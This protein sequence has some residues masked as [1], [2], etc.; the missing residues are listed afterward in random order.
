MTTGTTRGDPGADANA[1]VRT[2]GATAGGAPSSAPDAAL[3]R[4][5]LGLHGPILVLGAS[6]FV[7]A[8]LLRMLLAVRR[9]AYGTALRFPAWRLEGLPEENVVATDLLVPSNLRALLDRV[10]PLTVFDC[11]AYGAYSYERD[12]HL[13]HRTNAVFTV[14]LAEELAA[15]GIRALVHAGSS[16]EYGG[17][18]AAP[19][20]SQAPLPN[21]HYAAS[22]VAAAATLGFM[23]RERALP[24]ANLRLYSVYGPY[25]DASR[26]V[27]QLVLRGLA[28]ELPPFV[29]PAIS[30]DLVYVDD[31]CEAF[32]DAALRLEPAIYGESFNVGTGTCTRIG[33]VAEIARAEFGIAAA[34]VF[35]MPPRAWDPRTGG[36]GGP[37]D[38]VADPTRA[39]A[40]LGWRARTPF[41][42]GLRR[43][44]AWVEGLSDL[45]AYRASSKA[46]GLET[47]H[48]VSA[49]VACYKDAQAI[50]ILHE[51]LT[52]TFEKLGIDY[53]IVFV[54]DGSPDDSEEVIRAISARDRRVTGISHSR[55][56]GSQAA[57]RSGME[58]ATKN[59]CVLLDGDLQ[60]P[61]ELIEAF[62][63]KWREGFD[64]VYGRRVAREAPFAMRVA[65]KAFYRL[66]DRFSYL[67]IPHDAGD[68]ALMDKRVVRA[69]LQFPERDLFLRGVR[70]FVGFRQT[71]VD[72]VR[73][74]RMF[75]RS[76]NNLLRN[77]G[78]A[79][80]GI[81]SF[82]RAPLDALSTAGVLGV[83]LFGLLG[84]AQFTAKLLFPSAAP[85]GITTVL[86]VTLFLGS[87]N[88]LAISL[89]GEYIAKIF[90]EVKRR[91]HFLRRAIVRDGEVRDAGEVPRGADD[92]PGGR[93]P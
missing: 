87:L 55:N 29:D 75:G 4:R 78:W 68:F 28:G 82:S 6:G 53:E 40:A 22:K 23:G 33:E 41:A 85:K 36:E 58:I 57:F 44:R 79:K 74:E 46:F 48:S 20:E 21:S 56:F 89:V 2:A 32:V 66:F 92:G 51:R 8:N 84:V 13:I 25:E 73:P 34:P 60:D 67:E 52:A 17:A 50:P 3:E 42:E 90:E 47:G 14:A 77:I 27:P 39:A 49:I 43:T 59:A 37:A 71:G 62:V 24:C 5:I 63:A 91:P 15:R 12:P 64:V 76:T 9:D 26:L 7:G 30:R 38:W 11:V 86:L 70:A 93:A 69:M 1:G 35:D 80:K 88:L 45:D 65:Y 16:S 54:N 31:A 10:R 83:A 81:L 18:S 19:P 61:P 72:Y